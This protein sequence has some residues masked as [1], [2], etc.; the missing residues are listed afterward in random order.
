[1]QFS[2]HEIGPVLVV[3]LPFVRLD[4]SVARDARDRLLKLAGTQPAMVFDLSRVL[5][6]D[7]FGVD[8][9]LEAVQACPGKACIGGVNDSLE[10]LLTMTLGDGILATFPTVELAVEQCSKANPPHLHLDPTEH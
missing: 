7:A 10:N 4:R 8:L 6:I 5:Y 9:L 1:M 2:T 3:P